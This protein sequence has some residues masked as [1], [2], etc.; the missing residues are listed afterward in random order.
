M[1]QLPRTDGK[2]R[3]RY[4][5]KINPWPLL[6]HTPVPHRSHSN[7]KSKRT[8]V[9]RETLTRHDPLAHQLLPGPPL[10][11]LQLQHCMA[12]KRRQVKSV[13]RPTT[14][15]TFSNAENVQKI[16]YIVKGGSQTA[17]VCN[18]RSGLTARVSAFCCGR[19]EEVA[20]GLAG[21]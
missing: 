19:Q 13:S 15:D 20:K 17:T 6:L 9:E 3:G 21:R 16:S 4:N 2:V 11:E 7:T 12:A 1:T 14:A 5:W 10:L 18:C 8:N